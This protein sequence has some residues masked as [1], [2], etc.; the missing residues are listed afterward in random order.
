MLPNPYFIKYFK[1][2]LLEYYENLYTETWSFVF[3]FVVTPKMKTVKSVPD[4]KDLINGAIYLNGILS[5]MFDILST[6][7]PFKSL[8]R[9]TTPPSTNNVVT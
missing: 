6:N 4:V 3:V 8:H 7:G 1:I 5:K 2:F 9:L